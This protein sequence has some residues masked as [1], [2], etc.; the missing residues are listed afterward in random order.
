MVEYLAVVTGGAQG[1][2]L[3]IVMEL[4]EAGGKVYFIDM[5]EEQGKKAEKDLQHR[6]GQDRVKFIKCD[7]SNEKEFE[8]SIRKAREEMRGLNVMCNNAGFAR[9]FYDMSRWE[10]EIDVNL[11]ASIRGSLIALELMN[12]ENNGSGGVIV[13]T[14]SYTGLNPAPLFPTYCA[15]KAGVIAFARG[16]AP[17]AVTSN[18]RINCVLP[19]ATMT[20]MY[21]KTL[22][23]LASTLSQEKFQSFMKT[24][25]SSQGSKQ[26]ISPNTQEPRDVALGVIKIL[27][28]ETKN[29]EALV[30]SKEHGTYYHQFN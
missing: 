27:Q 10:L 9:P 24:M 4:L 23:E 29:G 8:A 3:A 2:G 25:T 14:S 18:V 16:F 26:A 11:K 7:V 30:V 1:I 6:Y 5:D 21:Q 17:I 22:P 13:N 28:D 20:P 19:D 15:A 12:P